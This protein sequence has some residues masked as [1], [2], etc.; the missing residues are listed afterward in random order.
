MLSRVLT[1]LAVVFYL[2]GK[3]PHTSCNVLHSDASAVTRTVPMPPTLMYSI[4]MGRIKYNYLALTLESMRLNPSVTFVIINIVQNESE[5][6]HHHGNKGNLVRNFGAENIILRVISISTWTNIVE[7]KLGIR[8]PFTMA[9]YYK[10]CDYKPLLAYLFPEYYQAVSIVKYRYWGYCDLDLVWGSFQQF[11]YLF[12]GQFYIIRTNW[13]NVNG[14][15][16]FFKLDNFTTSIFLQDEMYV[17]LLKE[18]VYRNLDEVG[19]WIPTEN[20]VDDGS[21]SIN[22]IVNRLRA[23]DRFR[24]TVNVG[25]HEDDNLFMEQHPNPGGRNP[26]VSWVGGRLRVIHKTRHFPPGRELLYMHRMSNIPPIPAAYRKGIIRD[27]I[28]YGYL[29][30]GWIPLVTRFMCRDSINSTHIKRDGVRTMHNY[31]PYDLLCFGK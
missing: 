25:K 2:H 8:V 26:A 9:W 1:L 12:Q 11:S 10:L 22:S 3:V 15:A 30:P 18:N 23:T 20:V 29:L 21:H 17:N 16:Q 4:Y 19:R 5:A 24:F 7:Q 14:M 27:M 28:T 6:F 13:W 31:H